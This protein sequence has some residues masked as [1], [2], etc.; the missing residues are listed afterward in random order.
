VIVG[1]GLSGLIAAN[2]LAVHGLRSVVVDKG[3]SAGGR[4]ATRRIAGTNGD[5]ARFDH[6]AQF[7]TVRSPDFAD[8]VHEWRRAGLVREWCHGFRSGGDGYPRYCAEGGM[9]TIAKF[10]ASTSD[11]VC[12]V[13]LHA[14][15]GHDGALSVST[16]D[17]RRWET[18]TVVLTPPVP[19]SLALCENGWLPIPAADE[20]EL[21][22]L[23]YAPCLALLVAID[24]DSLVPSPGGLQFDSSED[25]TFSFIGDNRAKGISE[26]GALTFHANDTVSQRRFDEDTEDTCT[27]LL[28][29][30]QR[31]LGTSSI[32][33][34]QLKKWRYARPVMVSAVSFIDVEPIPGTR[35]LFAGDAF[36]EGK[37]E[38]A[39]LSGLR[40]AE[41]VL[42]VRG[43][44]AR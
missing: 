14:V 21:Q 38:G 32:V 9:N 28:S 12:D 2:V 24:G 23:T 22:K 26:V 41:R 43:E 30:A 37:I 17:G 25:A 36:G 5:A 4:L 3:R 16:E 13:R 18:D 7:F 42:A 39:A 44:S 1:A 27:Y 6:G 15:A 10:L 34:V 8:V 33:N 31:F 40:V 29:E 19:Q 20:I 35:L 11:V